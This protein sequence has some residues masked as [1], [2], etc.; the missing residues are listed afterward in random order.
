LQPS[1]IFL[2]AAVVWGE[3]ATRL[4]IGGLAISLFGAFLVLSQADPKRLFQTGVNTGDLWVFGCVISWVAYTLIGRTMA[5]RLS[6]VAATAYSTWMGTALL[7]A[8]GAL[9]PA[10]SAVWSSRVWLA[11]VF[12]GIFGTAI[13]FLFYLQGLRQ[14]GASRASIFVNLVP[15]FGVI[16]SSVVLGESLSGATLAGGAC[17]IVGVRMLNR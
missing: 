11:T 10:A 13:A 16:F 2:F 9:Q 14:I 17:V 4:K 15:V 7:L 12:L 1:V 3:R 5:G 8:F 6:V